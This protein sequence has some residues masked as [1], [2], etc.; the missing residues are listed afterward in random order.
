MGGSY[1]QG[2][3][4]QPGTTSLGLEIVGETLLCVTER[5]ETK[6]TSQKAGK[7]LGRGEAGGGEERKLA[8]LVVW[9]KMQ[10]RVSALAEQLSLSGRRRASRTA[11]PAWPVSSE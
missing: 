9:G 1:A 3:P 11:T 4:R 6:P 5:E 10:R 7:T 2:P 8:V